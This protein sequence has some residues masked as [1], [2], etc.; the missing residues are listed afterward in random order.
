M[1]TAQVTSR[2][3][4]GV[5]QKPPMI[6]QQPN[7][8]RG[9][10]VLFSKSQGSE[11][12]VAIVTDVGETTVSGSILIPASRSITY[13]QGARHIQ[14][15]SLETSPPRDGVWQYT[16]QTELLYK[17]KADYETRKGFEEG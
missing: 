4:P 1:A 15:P 14:D 5:G 3:A 8:S 16:A 17:L 13:F 6:F 12:A 7:I 11:Q 10:T 9:D 2:P